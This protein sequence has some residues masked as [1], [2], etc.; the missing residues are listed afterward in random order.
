M[1]FHLLLQL[2]QFICLLNNPVG[3]F[4]LPSELHRFANTPQAFKEI[5][6]QIPSLSDVPATIKIKIWYQQPVG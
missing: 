4:I 6:I 2:V 5:V 1:F 3:P